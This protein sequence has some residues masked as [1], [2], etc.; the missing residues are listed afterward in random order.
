M[1]SAITP[2]SPADRPARFAAWSDDIKTRAFALW[3][4]VAMGSAPRTEYLLAQEAGED[5]AVPASS[6]IRMW[7][8]QGGW[9]SRADADLVQTH[10]RTLRQL[11]AIGLQTIA[12]AHSTMLDAMTGMLDD[13]PY[14]E[15][16]ESAPRK[17]SCG[18]PS[19]AAS[20][21]CV[22]RLIPCPTRRSRS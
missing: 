13:A 16:R 9:T 15:R 18:W 14:G 21:C 2:A 5:V 8:A 4:T 1:T 19:G 7:A 10:G 11:Q 17:P 20:H 6:T 22:P 3:S 12:L